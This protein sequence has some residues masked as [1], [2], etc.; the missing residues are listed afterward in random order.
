[1]QQRFLATA[2]LFAATVVGRAQSTISPTGFVYPTGS[3]L[4]TTGN[5]C[6][7][8]A[9]TSA[10][11]GLGGC[12]KFAQSY[13]NGYDIRAGAWTP[14]RLVSAGIVIAISYNGWTC[15]P[16]AP[17][18][19]QNVA[20]LVKHQSADGLPFIGL[21]GHLKKTNLLV[22]IN[23][24]TVLPAGMV[25]GYVGSWPCGGDHLH[26]GVYVPQW[27][28]GTDSPPYAFSTNPAASIGYGFIG[29]THWAAMFGW[30]HPINFIEWKQPGW[31]G[32]TTLS[33]DDQAKLD[34]KTYMRQHTPYGSNP[35]DATFGTNLNWSSGFELRWLQFGYT[36]NGAQ[37]SLYVYHATSK[38][39]RSQ[40]WIGYIDPITSFWQGW[41]A[42]G[43]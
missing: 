2:L 15:D 19:D 14:V 12:Y 3:N 10:D 4:N 6:S 8:F 42:V 33:A 22:G 24:Q 25:I 34:M 30:V 28:N 16:K 36:F 17:D 11:M 18:Q 1:M 41:Y 29:K 23:T 39:N 38:Q 26:F 27:G 32:T 5:M 43:N 21:Y 13:H 9:A 20:V 35:L 40:R 31:P 37:R 7:G